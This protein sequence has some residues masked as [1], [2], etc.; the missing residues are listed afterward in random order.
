[1]LLKLRFPIQNNLGS[2][3]LGNPKCWPNI[4][5]R[6]V[7]KSLQTSLSLQ[8]QLAVNFH[9]GLALA[10]NKAHCILL[11]IWVGD[12]NSLKAKGSR[13]REFMQ[14]SATKDEGL[15]QQNWDLPSKTMDFTL[16]RWDLS[17]NT[18]DYVTRCSV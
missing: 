6:T 3:T 10:A 14:T 8:S 4:A 1:M 2:P 12:K 18:E 5:N 9:L 16:K 7:T 13:K 15:N 17:N 11:F